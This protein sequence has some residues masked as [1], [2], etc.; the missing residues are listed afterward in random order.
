MT[1]EYVEG[2]YNGRTMLY[3]AK[4]LSNLPIELPPGFGVTL[5]AYSDV[6]HHWVPISNQ[7]IYPSQGIAIYPKRDGQI[8]YM[9][10]IHINPVLPRD[11]SYLLAR[12]VIHGTLVDPTDAGDDSVYAY[13]T[14]P[15]SLLVDH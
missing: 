2:S 10:Q 5:L 7:I 4:N 6:S 14:I 12:M 1:L 8:G 15:L 9:A 11:E 3:L 13:S